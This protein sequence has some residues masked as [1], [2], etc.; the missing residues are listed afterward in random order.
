MLISG[1]LLTSGMLLCGRVVGVADA[2]A[3]VYVPAPEL[4]MKGAT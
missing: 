4:A 3:G 1:L 2:G